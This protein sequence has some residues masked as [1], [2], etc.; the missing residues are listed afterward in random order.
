VR[1][2]ALRDL[3]AEL[4]ALGLPRA[5]EEIALR[6]HALAPEFP[7]SARLVAASAASERRQDEDRPAVPRRFRILR[8]LGAGSLGRVYAAQDE[9]LGRTVA[10]KLLS[11]GPGTQGPERQAW[12]R[13]LRESEASARLHHPNIV[14]VHEMRPEE[15]LLVE[16][17]LE[18]GTLAERLRREGPL[19]PAVV[20][21]LALDLLAG[22][23]EAHVQGIVHRDI[24]PANILFDGLG[25]AK[26]ADFGAA[27]LLDFGQTQ[28]G[29]FIGTLAY[30]SPEQISGSPIGPTV[31]LYALAATLFE[32]LAGRTPFLGP[33]LVAQHLGT[34]PPSLGQLRP[35]LAPAFDETLGRALAKSPSDRFPS[36]HA[37]AQSISAWPDAA[38][39]APLHAGTDPTPDEDPVPP[40]IVLGRSPRSRV[41]LVHE[42]RVHREVLR[43]ELDTPLTHDEVEQVRALAAQG[44]PHVQRIL[45]LT[46]DLRTLTYEFLPG[47]TARLDALSPEQREVLGPLWPRLS[48]LGFP[49]LPEREIMQTPAGPVV[50]LAPDYQAAKS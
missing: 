39:P 12:E 19:Q 48:P 6:L 15:G 26:L 43:E 2:S 32:A 11:V 9:L 23:Q 36:A 46:P 3:C 22:L 13:M 44:G 37:M 20:R 16:E 17:Y 50:V 45:G 18:G 7:A 30:L 29:G 47:Q 41:L 1:G 14:A 33:D 35:G 25:N 4:W 21:R 5:A 38:V 40:P 10:L 49:P 8:S 27:H 42:P 34:P 31:D 24:K 28:T